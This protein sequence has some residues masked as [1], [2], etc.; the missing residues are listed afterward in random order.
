MIIKDFLTEYFKNGGVEKNDKILLHSNL[1]ELFKI[2]KRKGF[3]FRV[4][5]LLEFI[6]DY[7]GQ[8]GTL[9]LPSF[10]FDFCTKKYYSCKNTISKMGALTEKGR[11]KAGENKTW[12]PVYPFTV[13]GKIPKAEIEK[14]NYSALGR[15]SIFNWLV[16]NNGKISI[17]NLNDQNSMT[18]YHHVEELLGASWRVKKIFKGKYETFQ[19]DIIDVDATIYVRDLKKGVKTD[20][21]N[22]EKLLWSKNLYKSN[23]KNSNKGLRS[24][25]S[26]ILKKEV[27]TVIK[28]NLGNKMLYRIKN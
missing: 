25:F 23:I 12:H 18:F 5:D 6:I 16:E 10:N 27:E 14:K 8:D 17:L 9:I 13:F 7:L 20:V 24:I 15:E 1:S 19:D 26:T 11:L 2:T 3:T 22:M 21:N 4:E 28:S